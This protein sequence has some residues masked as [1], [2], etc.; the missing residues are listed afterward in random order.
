MIACSLTTMRSGSSSD[1]LRLS[2]LLSELPCL[3]FCDG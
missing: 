2:M 1:G 3:G